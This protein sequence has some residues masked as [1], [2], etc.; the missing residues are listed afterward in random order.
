[1]A[2]DFRPEVDIQNHDDHG[3]LSVRHG[4]RNCPLILIYSNSSKLLVVLER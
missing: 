3:D 1:M 2:K 4:D